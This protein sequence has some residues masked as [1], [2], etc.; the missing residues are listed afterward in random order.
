[1][2]TLGDQ[3]LLQPEDEAG[4]P[5][6]SAAFMALPPGAEAYACGPIGMPRAA[7]RAW[8]AAGR[9]PASLV[10]ETFGSSGAAAPSDFVVRIPR[11][12]GGSITIEPAWRGDAPFVPG[13]AG[14]HPAGVS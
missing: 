5:D 4:R 14:K 8:E 6:F 1:M 12:A 10:F 13:H 3:L 11:L 9:P 7:R 2:A